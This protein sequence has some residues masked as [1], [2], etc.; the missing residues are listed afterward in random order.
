MQGS[1]VAACDENGRL[2]DMEGL[3]PLAQR[4]EDEDESENEDEEEDD[5]D[6]ACVH[7]HCGP[8]WTQLETGSA[9][10]PRNQDEDE[11]KDED[12]G[13]QYDWR[14]TGFGPGV[15]EPCRGIPFCT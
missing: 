7:P 11:D 14:E 4:G 9:L 12:E 10:V 6:V 2:L 15:F 3:Y 1:G 13:A 5:G 8:W